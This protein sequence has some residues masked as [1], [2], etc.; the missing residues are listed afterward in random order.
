[1]K[2]NQMLFL[3]IFLLIMLLFSLNKTLANEK[4]IYYDVKNQKL[5]FSNLYSDDLFD[6]FKDL[7]PGD[8]KEQEIKLIV[9]GNEGINMYLKIDHVD[10]KDILNNIDIKFLKDGNELIKNNEVFKII[11]EKDQSATLKMI[12]SI[13]TSVDNEIEGYNN[14][15]KMT[16]YVENNNELEEVPKTYENSIM[17]YYVLL[18]TSAIL[19]VLVIK[20]VLEKETSN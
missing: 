3:G 18:F 7:I 12:L 19:L 13:P 2:K 9:N 20:K 4:A 6:E 17:I 15:F 10:N 14:N 8:V 11:D 5:I 1:M 16:F